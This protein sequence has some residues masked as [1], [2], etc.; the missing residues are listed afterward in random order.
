MA[1]LGCVLSHFPKSLGWNQLWKSAGSPRF[2]LK[3]RTEQDASLEPHR[4]IFLFSLRPSFQHHKGKIHLFS[5]VF[6]FFKSG[7]KIVFSSREESSGYIFDNVLP[8]PWVSYHIKPLMSHKDTIQKKIQ[9]LKKF[10]LFLL[11]Q[12]F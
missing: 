6:F 3:I 8:K 10:P 7:I 2:V 5:T 1:V 11:K 9:K 4:F 12:Y